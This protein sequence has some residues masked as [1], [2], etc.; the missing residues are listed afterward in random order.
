MWAHPPPP[1]PPTMG[2]T[3]PVKCSPCSVFQVLPWEDIRIH[4]LAH[5]FKLS[6]FNSCIEC[7]MYLL[8]HTWL[9]LLSSVDGI[10]NLVYIARSNA[11]MFTWVNMCPLH[12]QMKAQETEDQL[13]QAGAEVFALQT[14]LCTAGLLPA[15]SFGT[16][17]KSGKLRGAEGDVPEGSRRSVLCQQEATSLLEHVSCF[18]C[19]DRKSERLRQ[20]DRWEEVGF[21]Y[22]RIISGPVYDNWRNIHLL[23]RVTCGISLEAKAEHKKSHLHRCFPL[24]TR[25]VDPL[26]SDRRKL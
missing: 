4:A 2:P 17:T 7:F 15:P 9:F 14:A 23:S 5:R 8:T 22:V 21:I 13:I 11:T 20:H 10:L 18:L 16:P 1:P 12:V 3:Y 19:N 6:T 25:G 24:T 26:T